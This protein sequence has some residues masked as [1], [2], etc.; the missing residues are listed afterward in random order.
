MPKKFI[1]LFIAAGLLV[2]ASQVGAAKPETTPRTLTLPPQ[3]FKVADN[4]FYMGKTPDPQSGKLLEGYAIVH[5]KDQPIKPEKPGKPSKILCYAF[6]A[7]GAKW[8]IVEDW[9]VNAANNSRLSSAFIFDNLTFDIAKWE[10]AAD[11]V[12]ENSIS[13]N[14]LGNGSVTTS[15]LSVDFGKLNGNNEVYFAPLSNQNIIALTYI[16][17]I[18]G[19]PVANRELDE[20]DQIYNDNYGWS[21]NG[22]PT[23][24]DFENIATHE[25]GHSVGLDDLYKSN[26]SPET[27]YG[28]ASYGETKKQTLESGDVTG[29][30]QLYR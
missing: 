18:S 13:K 2:A 26:C 12:L 15:D 23:K 30:S 24:M 5:Y 22:E 9:M 21:L 25:L 27:M 14:I 10:D 17:G 28:Y 20:W 16:W 7:N 6:L 8:K 1:V 29:V 11:G 19:G 3:A 4:I